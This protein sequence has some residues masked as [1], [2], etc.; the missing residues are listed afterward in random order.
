MSKRSVDTHAIENK[1]N[2]TPNKEADLQFCSEA[3]A[4]FRFFKNGGVF[5]PCMVVPAIQSRRPENL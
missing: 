3:P 4:Q 1:L 5:A 2:L